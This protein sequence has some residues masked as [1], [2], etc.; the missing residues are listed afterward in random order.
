MDF[1]LKYI[2]PIVALTVLLI[3]SWLLLGEYFFIE[4]KSGNTPFEDGE[5][6]FMDDEYFFNLYFFAKGLFSASMV[7]LFG[8]FFRRWLQK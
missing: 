3:C 6:M 4:D 8:E 1:Y 5:N 2:N 7:F